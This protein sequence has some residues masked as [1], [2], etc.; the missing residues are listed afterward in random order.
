VEVCHKCLLFY[1]LFTLYL[2]DINHLLTIHYNFNPN[3]PRLKQQVRLR[4]EFNVDETDAA[5]FIIAALHTTD[6]PCTVSYEAQWFKLPCG[7]GFSGETI[8]KLRSEP[9]S[10]CPNC[11]EPFEQ[12]TLVDK[13]IL[14][15]RLFALSGFLF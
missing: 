11:R 14:K 12:A 10:I 1:R 9:P 6:V 2:S 5:N 4:T 15:R 3:C 8:S 13:A 7:H